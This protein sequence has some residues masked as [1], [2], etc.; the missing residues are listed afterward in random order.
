LP[1]LPERLK[2]EDGGIRS[3]LTQQLKMPESDEKALK[4][5]IFPLHESHA[6]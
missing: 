4:Q 6:L 1:I 5:R 2:S 3:L